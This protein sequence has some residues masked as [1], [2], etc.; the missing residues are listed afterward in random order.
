MSKS[1]SSL[2]CD[3]LTFAQFRDTLYYRLDGLDRVMVFNKNGRVTAVAGSLGKNHVQAD[4][5]NRPMTMVT[6]G[7]MVEEVF[8]R[9]R[10]GRDETTPS[11]E[12]ALFANRFR[13][14]RH[15]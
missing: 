10:K 3:E 7:K 12:P 6:A 2:A 1:S 8:T 5:G 15:T 14:E 4:A 13:R 11:G 9:L